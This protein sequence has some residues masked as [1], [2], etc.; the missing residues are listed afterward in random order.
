MSG[1]SSIFSANEIVAL[2][3]NIRHTI[4]SKEDSSFIIVSPSFKNK[5]IHYLGRQGLQQE[6]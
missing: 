5:T 2:Y 1:K 4:T 3:T 6:K